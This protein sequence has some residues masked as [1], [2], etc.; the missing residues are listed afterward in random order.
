MK[1]NK[2][3]ISNNV[4]SE[5]ALLGTKHSVFANDINV[6]G[7]VWAYSKR[8]KKVNIENRE[9]YLKQ[10][11]DKNPIVIQIP[12]IEI[13]KDML[14]HDQSVWCHEWVREVLEKNDLHV[15]YFLEDYR[16]MRKNIHHWFYRFAVGVLIFLTGLVIGWSLPYQLIL[17][18]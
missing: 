7:H 12:E 14:E 3:I 9:K 11:W 2:I 1:V 16:S 10:V 18:N 4:W 8:T 13:S 5:N 17:I 6:V 15:P